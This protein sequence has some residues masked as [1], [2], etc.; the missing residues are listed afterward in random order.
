MASTDVGRRAE[1]EARGFLEE[2]GF[3]ILATNW[4]NRW[5]E[6]DLVASRGEVIHVIEV[7]Y[8]SN[9]DFGSGLE[10][11]TPSKLDRLSRA[12]E[13]FMLKHHLDYPYQIDVIAITGDLA[14]PTLELIEN[15]TT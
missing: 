11:I 7:K 15:I 14:K 12:A 6:I 10:Y 8:R 5:C 1:A 4:R 13:I 3:R 9:L 2:S